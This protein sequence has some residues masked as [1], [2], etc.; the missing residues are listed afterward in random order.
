MQRKADPQALTKRT[1]QNVSG[2]ERESPQRDA[3]HPF[4]S[5]AEKLQLRV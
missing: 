5:K 1:F 3:R 2:E 4:V